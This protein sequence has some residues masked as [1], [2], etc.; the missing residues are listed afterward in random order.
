VD[1]GLFVATEKETW[2][3]GGKDFDALKLTKVLDYG[4]VPGTAAK[5]DS[6]LLSAEGEK[7]GPAVT[8]ALWTSPFGVILGTTGGQ[9]RNLTEENYSFPTAPRGAG[10][11]RTSRGYTSYLSVLQGEGEALNKY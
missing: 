8:A 7:A 5:L 6:N 10:L 1:D 11:I 3:M 4:A 9:V 2:F